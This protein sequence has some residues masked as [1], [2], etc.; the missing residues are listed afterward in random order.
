[1][2]LAEIGAIIIVILLV[3]ALGGLYLYLETK[4]MEE[5]QQYFILREQW[6]ERNGEK[7][8]EEV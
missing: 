4:E 8:K 7:D 6:R 5:S 3:S 1:M 2:E